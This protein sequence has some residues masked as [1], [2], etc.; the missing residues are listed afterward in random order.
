MYERVGSGTMDPNMSD[1]ENA[2]VAVGIGV[3]RS[4]CSGGPVRGASVAF[5]SG[6]LPSVRLLPGLVE[7]G[8]DDATPRVW[9]GKSRFERWGC[10]A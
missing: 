5:R 1:L 10:P 7:P 6:N 3:E 9:T 4:R 8:F 2:V